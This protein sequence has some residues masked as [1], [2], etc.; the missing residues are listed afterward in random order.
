MLARMD[1]AGEGA[2]GPLRRLARSVVADVTPLRVS[3]P[4]RRLWIGLAVSNTGAQLTSV[5][6]AI[7]VYSVSGSNLAVG[8]VGGV[9]LVPLIVFGLYG[10]AIADAVDR[11]TLMLWTA[12]G[13]AICSAVLLAQAL[14][15]VR[16]VLLLYL[17]VAVQSGLFAVNNPART[18]AIPRLVGLELLPAAN[19]LQQTATPDALRG[20]LQ[21]VFVVVVAGGPRLGDVESGAVAS[22]TNET[23]SIVSG[24]LLCC[25]GVLLLAMLVPSFARYSSPVDGEVALPDELPDEI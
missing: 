10:G 3:V 13:S 25:V 18:A 6:V 23:I 8:L 16:S 19:A 4:Y 15:D 21:G 14:L 11:R 5:V 22:A 20:R 12:V 2:P 9:A 24:G 7:Q 1:G 17:V